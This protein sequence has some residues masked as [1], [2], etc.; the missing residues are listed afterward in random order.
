MRKDHAVMGAKIWCYNVKLEDG[1][2]D[3]QPRNTRNAA[4]K[5]NE[6]DCLLKLLQE[7]S[8]WRHLDLAP[9]KL[10]WIWISDFQNS[11]EINLCYFKPLLS[12]WQ[13]VIAI[14]GI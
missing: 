9:V 13:F 4:E 14:T 10:I 5:G 1:G 7:A 2:R 6:I 12:G 3:H 11:K 8:S